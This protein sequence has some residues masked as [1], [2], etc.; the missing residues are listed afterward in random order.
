MDEF[1]ELVVM[2][3]MS[4]NHRKR[5]PDEKLITVFI[6]QFLLGVTQI[7]GRKFLPRG[8]IICPP[9]RFHIAISAK[10]F[11][12]RHPDTGPDIPARAG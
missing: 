3:P 6:L 8:R 2:I 10:D 12:L 5:S 4:P 11:C 9:Q 7:R 1:V